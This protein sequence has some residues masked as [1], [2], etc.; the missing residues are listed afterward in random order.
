M[1]NRIRLPFITNKAQFPTAR[2]VFRRADG[3]TQVLSAVVRN[4]YQLTTDYLPEKWH[5]RLVIALNHDEVRIE[6]DIYLGGVA[7]DAEYSIDWL[8]FKD[9]PVAQ[10]STTIQ[11]TPFDATNSNCQTC[12][13][14]T[15]LSLEDDTFPTDVLED[16]TRTLDVLA[17]DNICCYPANPEVV[18]FNTDFLTAASFIS[19]VLSITVKE[20]TGTADNVKLVTYRVNCADG[21]YDEADV[22]G[23]VVGTLTACNPPGQPVVV[24]NYYNG[25]LTEWPDAS[26]VPDSYDWKVVLASNPSIV[27][28]SGNTD[29]NFAS[30]TG[31]SDGTQ[32]IFIVNSNCGNGNLSS[33]Q[34]VNFTTPGIP[35]SAS[36]GNYEIYPSGISGSSNLTYKDCSGSLQTTTITPFTVRQICMLQTAPGLPDTFDSSG[37]ISY[38]YLGICGTSEYNTYENTALSNSSLSVC[39]APAAIVYLLAPNTTITPGIT[40]Y[41]SPG[42]PYTGYSYIKDAGG[43]I[44]NL[45]PANGIVGSATGDI[46]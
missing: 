26:P 21:S 41:S 24:N 32:Y 10:G 13:Q 38:N 36:C 7:I 16:T 19:G 12:E 39:G 4:T 27:L 2:N 37:G 5:K 44:Y 18:W 3:S 9:Y 20:E 28:S 6:N 31:L 30:Y 33:T 17:N 25:G 11:V 22:L 23:D 42:V 14:A 46:C 8:E 1:I 15:Q 35:S 45:N 40:I 43:V 29:S 34:M